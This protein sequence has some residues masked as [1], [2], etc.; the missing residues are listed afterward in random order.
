MEGMS[1]AGGA[2]VQRLSSTTYQSRIE[3]DGPNTERRR[4]TP[5]SD[6]NIYTSPTRIFSPATTTDKERG[7]TRVFTPEDLNRVAGTGYGRNVV[8]MEIEGMEKPIDG[9]SMSTVS[10]RSAIYQKLLFDVR[11]Q[12]F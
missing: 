5:G 3:N 11:S 4:M 7:M 8:P 12:P 1:D 9:R 2:P 10:Q 6:F